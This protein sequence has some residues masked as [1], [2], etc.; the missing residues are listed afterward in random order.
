MNTTM[1]TTGAEELP[2]CTAA[3]GTTEVIN[4][5]DHPLMVRAVDF[6]RLHAQVE[7]LSAALAGV[8]DDFLS[9]RLAWRAAI[10]QCDLSLDVDDADRSYWEYELRAFDRAYAALAAAPQPTPSTAQAP[11]VAYLDLGAGGY[12]DLGTDLSEEDI[13]ALPKGRHMLVIAGT[14][15]VDGYRPSRAR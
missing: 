12:V 15:G 5:P 1:N 3:D 13:A 2:K 6:N 9:H 14:Y 7:A 10:V 11:H 8:Q 4:V